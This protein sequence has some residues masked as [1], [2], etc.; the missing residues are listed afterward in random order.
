MKI[1]SIPNYNLNFRKTLLGYTNVKTAR[2]ELQEVDFVEYDPNNEKDILQISKL[3]S[4]WGRQAKYIK[5]IIS[6]FLNINSTGS[7]R[8]DENAY[9]YGLEDKKGKTL[10]IAEVLEDNPGA[11]TCC[12]SEYNYSYINYMQA[13]PIN[14]LSS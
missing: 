3:K 13:D 14:P 4:K 9:F 12:A 1:N 2:G 8:T 11:N 10:A 6:E 5:E 7:Y